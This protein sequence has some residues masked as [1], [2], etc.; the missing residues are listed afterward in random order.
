[1]RLVELAGT[2]EDMTWSK[3]WQSDED[4][5]LRQA[6]TIFGEQSWQKVADFV[7]TRKLCA[8]SIIF[9]I[10]FRVI[11]CGLMVFRSVPAALD[12]GTKAR[13]RQGALERS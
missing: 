12:I 5:R 11:L 6:I 8:F 13:H 4:E 1:M 7:G 3:R 9:L 10:S 2:S